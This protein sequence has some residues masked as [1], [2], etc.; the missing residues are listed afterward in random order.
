VQHNC[1]FD[2]LYDGRRQLFLHQRLRVLSQLAVAEDLSVAGSWD[3]DGSTVAALAHLGSSLRSI[4]AKGIAKVPSDVLLLVL[5]QF[6]ERWAATRHC[7][8]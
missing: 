3:L 4:N 2:R 7:T 6:K 8:R 5:F 1:R